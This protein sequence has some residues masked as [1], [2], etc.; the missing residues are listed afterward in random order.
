M[1]SESE[2]RQQC[3]KTARYPR[4][5]IPVCSL[6]YKK[7]L[8]N[9]NKKRSEIE[10]TRAK[11]KTK[12]DALENQRSTLG[13]KTCEVN[14]SYQGIGHAEELSRSQR[15]QETRKVIYT[16]GGTKRKGRND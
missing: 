2:Q 14:K 12:K 8:Q 3:S 7:T 6:E 15:E 1:A 4:T 9:I 5:Q 16:P 13:L 10:E 11:I